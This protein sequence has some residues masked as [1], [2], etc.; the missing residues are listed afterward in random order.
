[1]SAIGIYSQAELGYIVIAA[2]LLTDLVCKVHGSSSFQ[3]SYL[4]T[5]AAAVALGGL[6]LSSQSLAVLLQLLHLRLQ[7]C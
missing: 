2:A 4:L 3:V 7:L 6:Q 1:M 5:K